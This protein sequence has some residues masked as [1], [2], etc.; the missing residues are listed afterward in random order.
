MRNTTHYYAGGLPQG[1]SIVQELNDEHTYILEPSR[2]LCFPFKLHYSYNQVVIDLANTTPF[3]NV[4]VPGQRCWPSTEPV[5]S[6]MTYSPL[7]TEASINLPPTGVKWNFYLEELYKSPLLKEA[8]IYK[9]VEHR[10]TYWM[11]VVN[12]QNKENYFFC[13]F[14]YYSPNTELIE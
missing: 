8:V 3:Q 9:M 2:T 1:A 5:G 13:R 12:L 7:P 4:Y 11:N 10:V 6:S 14:S